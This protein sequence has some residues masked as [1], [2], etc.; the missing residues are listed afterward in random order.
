MSSPH[1]ESVVCGKQLRELKALSERKN[2]RSLTA[3]FKKTA[4][5]FELV[6]LDL[7]QRDCV[8]SVQGKKQV[9]SRI[10]PF[11]INDNAIVVLM[12]PDQLAK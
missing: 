4:H 7:Q 8:L 1:F 6:P 3:C 11:Q 10:V 9:M 5:D 12:Y 2:S